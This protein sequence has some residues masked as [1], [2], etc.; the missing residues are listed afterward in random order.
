MRIAIVGG[1]AAGA[2]AAIHL[3]RNLKAG[4]RI[5]LFE[6][7]SE[8][9]RG[10][11]YADEAGHFL[12]NVPV[13]AMFWTDA[14]G[15]DFG[16]WL[17]AQATDQTL[18]RETDGSAFLPRALFG[19]H[20][21][22]MLRLEAAKSEVAFHHH[23]CLVH[24]ISPVAGGVRVHADDL[25]GA[26]FTHAVIAI[27]NAPAAEIPQATE[28]AEGGPRVVQSAWDIS[29][30]RIA[31]GDRVVILGAGL[32]MADCLAELEAR[33]HHGPVTCVSR[34]G[35]SPRLSQGTIADFTPSAPPGAG[36]ASAF[37]R[38]FRIM[39]DESLSQTGDWRPAFA[40]ARRNSAQIW[41]Q[42]N[43]QE[44]ARLRRHAR[45]LWDIHRYMMPPAAW[46][47]MQALETAGALTRVE[48][49]A[50]RIAAGG[51]VIRQAGG[52]Q[53]I[54]ADLVINATGF[55]NSYQTAAVPPGNLLD[56]TPAELAALPRQG[57]AVEDN[58]LMKIAANNGRIFAIGHLVRADHGEMGT[59][60]AFGAVARAMALHLA[61][62]QR[63]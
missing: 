6:P 26:G 2:I 39:V 58:G 21:V 59:V 3:L 49:R 50:L 19:S 20:L 45:A 42:L 57:L 63:S 60:N 22:Q 35:R 44:Q 33:G 30:A 12:L 8:I 10:I 62:E 18:W 31:P 48:G 54:P 43:R 4:A 7:R 14:A 15:D 41:R 38:H 55:D 11:A 27:G 40:F 17:D 53:L 16:R 5:D 37:F 23:Q 24:H 52:E 36:R 34:S 51:V 25:P 47:R 61:Q 9:G 1:G 46:R 56:L 29:L 32:T 13:P 28:S